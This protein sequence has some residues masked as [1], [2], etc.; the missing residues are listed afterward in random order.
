MPGASETPHSPPACDAPGRGTADAARPAGGLIRNRRCADKRRRAAHPVRRHSQQQ[1]G[2]RCLRK[3][4]EHPLLSKAD[5]EIVRH[6]LKPTETRKANGEKEAAS[7]SSRAAKQKAAAAN[8]F[9][10][11]FTASTSAR[12]GQKPGLASEA[13]ARP[14]QCEADCRRP[15]SFLFFFKRFSVYHG[16]RP[17]NTPP[18]KTK[19]AA[20]TVHHPPRRLNGRCA[21]RIPSGRCGIHRISA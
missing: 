2:V 19:A 14:R 13:P 18:R 16:A 6:K 20:R 3:S 15:F 5:A 21:P 1:S 10:P 11:A 7:V 8:D 17:A 9:F 12:P 4:T